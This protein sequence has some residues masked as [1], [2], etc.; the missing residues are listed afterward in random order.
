[1]YGGYAEPGHEGDRLQRRPR[2]VGQPF[3]LRSVTLML[4]HSARLSRRRHL[5][6]RSDGCQ[7]CGFQETATLQNLYNHANQPASERG[8][9]VLEGAHDLPVWCGALSLG[10][11][12][13]AS[14]RQRICRAA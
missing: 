7:Y 4:R 13:L 9:E 10:I 5:I 1:R 14:K 11:K 2:T 6:H 12:H 8:E 3:M